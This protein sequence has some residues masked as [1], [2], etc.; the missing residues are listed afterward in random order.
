MIVSKWKGSSLKQRME[1]A[2]N[3]QDWKDAAKQLDALEGKDKW[4][5]KDASKRYDA[6]L[7]RQQMHEMQQFKKEGQV[8]ELIDLL[9]ESMHRHLGDL[10]SS[11]LYRGAWAG[12]KHIITDYLQEVIDSIY[13]LVENDFEEVPDSYKLHMLRETDRN[14]G[15][16]AM[17][18]S[19]GGALGMFHFGVAKVLWQE[20]LLPT[21]MSGASMGSLVVGV[22]GTHTDDEL[23]EYF[24]HPIRSK[25]RPFKWNALRDI[26]TK[27]TAFSSES[28]VN[29][30][31][32]HIGNY[33]FKEAYERTGRVININVSP[34]RSHQKPRV[35]NHYTA[36]NLLICNSVVA[37]CSVPGLFPATS[38]KKKTNSGAIENYIPEEKWIDG[39]FFTD[40]PLKRL[41]RLHNVNHFV[42]SQTNPHVVPFVN[43]SR[44]PGLLPY[45][46][47]LFGSMLFNQGV[48]LLDVTRRR[49]HLYPVRPILDTLFSFSSQ[50]Y[51][52]DINI[53]PD[54]KWVDYIKVF[55]NISD[56][57]IDKLVLHGQQATFPKLP[58]IANQT[59][60]SSVFEECILFLEKKLQGESCG[61]P[62]R[63]Q[64]ER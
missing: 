28:L 41:M 20:G 24:Q 37:S 52:G 48:S 60:I 3:Y 62:F 57:E 63:V 43:A 13:Y 9:H 5:T 59:A 1:N 33:T 17:V 45:F 15:R 50:Q 16:T 12:T 64:L 7:L 26:F 51:T 31:H 55:Q 34:T 39:S 11:G 49:V 42:V 14:F 61:E 2:T 25:S 22:L 19:G 21:V 35:L 54:F 53:R 30:L 46:T 29:L 8:L 36:P 47:D 18:F 27:R 4:R 32:E 38:L 58:K 23:D 44:K 56:K 10:A 6:N 40:V